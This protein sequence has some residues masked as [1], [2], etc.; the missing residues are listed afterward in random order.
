MDTKADPVMTRDSEVVTS[1]MSAEIVRHMLEAPAALDHDDDITT[2]AHLIA[3]IDEAVP[4]VMIEPS[5]HLFE[6]NVAY[7]E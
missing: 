7:M 1:L 6:E 4:V 5:G 3:M 2:M